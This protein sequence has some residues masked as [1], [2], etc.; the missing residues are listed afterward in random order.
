M[1]NEYLDK[2]KAGAQEALKAAKEKKQAK[3]TRQ[4]IEKKPSAFV[5]ILNG[6][7]L[8]KEFMLGNLSFI[9]FV[10]FLLLLTVSKGYYG[11]RLSDG[12]NKTQL[13]L[14]ELTSDHFEAKTRL[15]E[16][17][18]RVKLVDELA[19][20]GLKETVNPTKVIRIKKK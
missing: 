17:T 12:V 2:D 11:K 15:E 8:T 1:D 7:F 13:E 5:Q 14:N 18:Q 3:R 20:R 19:P 16:E 4:K 10:M 9:F 6:D